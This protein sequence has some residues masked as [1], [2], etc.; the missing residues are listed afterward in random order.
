M[1]NADF[2]GWFFVAIFDPKFED[3]KILRICSF[4][5]PLNPLVP[6][7]T[8]TCRANGDYDI[9]KTHTFRINDVI[10]YRLQL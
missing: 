6:G 2:V 4:G 7:Y 10:L 1:I 3:I 5:K 9:I 8:Y